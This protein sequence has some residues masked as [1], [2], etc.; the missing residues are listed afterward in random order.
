MNRTASHTDNA[1]KA[2]GPYSQA[3]VAN[4]FVFCAGQTPV[5][6]S[7][8]KLVEGDVSAQTRRCL[9]NLAAV[10]ESAG[11]GWAHAVKVSVFLKDL[12]DFAAM[13]AVYAD[14]MPTPAPVRSTVEVAGLPLGA[15]VEIDVV[16]VLG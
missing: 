12:G 14:Y 10:L 4:G 15:R 11:S 6:P 2:L 13:N 16:A 7:T 9:D 3:I 1:P 5:D 8:G